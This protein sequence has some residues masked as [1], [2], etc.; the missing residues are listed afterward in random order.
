MKQFPMQNCTYVA[1]KYLYLEAYKV[2]F[3]ATLVNIA[4]I[5]RVL[6]IFMIVIVI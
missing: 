4:A 1:A 5:T 3:A 6:D 2:I